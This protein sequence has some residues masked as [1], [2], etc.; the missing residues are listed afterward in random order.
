MPSRPIAIAAA[1]G[2]VINRLEFGGPTEYTLAEEGTLQFYVELP[3]FLILGLVSGLVAVVFIARDSS[4]ARTWAHGSRNAYRI[5]GILRPPGD[6]AGAIP[7]R[8]SLAIRLPHIIGVG[9]E[10][11]SAGADRQPPAP[12]AIVFTMIKDY[13][14]WR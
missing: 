6:F 2:T 10:T 14:G 12:R 11:V 5:H 7:R 4:G 9:Y 13:R 3:A 8:Y 1:A